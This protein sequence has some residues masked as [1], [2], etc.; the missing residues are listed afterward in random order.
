MSNELKY[1]K[2]NCSDNK[3]MSVEWVK[4][5]QQGVP[6]CGRFGHTMTYL[7]VN[8]ALLIVGGRNDEVCK[9]QSTPFLN[10]IHLFLLD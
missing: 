7:P 6:P 1:L 9:A 3:V 2:P 5:K 8:Q 4:I 10:D